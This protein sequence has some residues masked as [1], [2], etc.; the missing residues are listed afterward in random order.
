VQGRETLAQA[1]LDRLAGRQGAHG[2]IIR[3][4]WTIASKSW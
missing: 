3:A 4:P 1:R 2:R